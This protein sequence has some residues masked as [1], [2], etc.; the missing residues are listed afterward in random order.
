MFQHL[1]TADI[2]HAFRKFL[3]LKEHTEF[4]ALW[5]R[6]QEENDGI[7]IK[8]ELNIPEITMDYGLQVVF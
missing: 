1:N 5:I 2:H 8:K 6:V 3:D 7:R 4:L